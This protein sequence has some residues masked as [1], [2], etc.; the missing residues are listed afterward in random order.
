[1]KPINKTIFFNK[2]SIHYI[3]DKE[4]GV[5]WL[6]LEDICKVLNRREMMQNGE[7]VSLCETCTK[8]P[9][10]TNGKLFWFIKVYDLQPLTNSIRKDNKNIAK[11][12]NELLKWACELP[13]SKVSPNVITQVVPEKK[14]VVKEG[15]TEHEKKELVV[16]QYNNKPISFKAENGK[17]YFNATEMARSFCKNPREWL[18]LSE[19]KRFRQSLVNQG[20]SESVESQIVTSRG[21][22]G[23]TWIEGNLGLEFS[24]WLSPQF[25][26]WCND[27]MQELFTDGIVTLENKKEPLYSTS[28]GVQKILPQTYKEA[29]LQLVAAEE[30][31]EKQQIKIEEDKPKVDFYNNIIGDRDS[32]RTAIIADELGISLVRLYQFLKEEQIVRWEKRLYQTYPNYHSL[33]CDHPY[34]WTNPRTGKTYVYGKSKRWTKAGRE[35]VLELYR[36]KNPK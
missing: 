14:K 29:L 15:T 12:C 1:M 26:N 27:R 28:Y 25:A 33:Q 16:F 36:K 7:A 35:F 19:T 32:F 21:N 9:I 18:N 11:L 6:C 2:S 13:I 4:G 30:V 31:V 22:I 8:F 24:R 20:K 23:V 5:G 10:Y 3:P 17:T 34:Y